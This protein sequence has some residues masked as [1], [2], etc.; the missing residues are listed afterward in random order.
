MCKKLTDV[1]EAIKIKLSKSCKIQKRAASQ[2]FW[3]QG[4]TPVPP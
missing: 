2:K 1:I 3:Y 4:V